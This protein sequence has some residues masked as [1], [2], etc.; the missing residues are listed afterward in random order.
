MI[1]KAQLLKP[2][3]A[4]TRNCPTY[5]R[6]YVIIFVLLIKETL[7]IL[8]I[9]KT[10][11]IYIKHCQKKLNLTFPVAT[12]KCIRKFIRTYIGNRRLPMLERILSKSSAEF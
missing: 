1:K 12:I 7:L 6:A 10:N 5:I 8:N 9:V 4:S 2:K 3:Q 11:S